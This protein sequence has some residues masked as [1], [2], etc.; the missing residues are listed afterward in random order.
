LGS[1]RKIDLSNYE[2][3]STEALVKFAR[4]HKT[5]TLIM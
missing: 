1:L 4:I 2:L 3:K 5:T